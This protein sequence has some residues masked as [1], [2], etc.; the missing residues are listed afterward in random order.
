MWRRSTN[1]ASP[2]SASAERLEG[3]GGSTGCTI[4]PGNDPVA[5]L[6][7]SKTTAA[8][9]APRTSRKWPLRS[10]FSSAHGGSDGS[11]NADSAR[12]YQLHKKS[13]STNDHGDNTA[14]PELPLSS[15]HTIIE[16]GRATKENCQEQHAHTLVVGQS[17]RRS[18]L[19]GMTQVR[20]RHGVLAGSCHPHASD[21]SPL[22]RSVHMNMEDWSDDDDWGRPTA[23]LEQQ[24]LPA[25]PRAKVPVE[26]G[27]AHV[28]GSDDVFVSDV[29]LAYPRHGQTPQS[30]AQELTYTSPCVLPSAS[31]PPQ[32]V[33]AS[34]LVSTSVVMAVAG[35]P[36]APTQPCEFSQT[37]P[38]ADCSP[39][40][41]AFHS[42]IRGLRSAHATSGSGSGAEGA[43]VDRTKRR[44]KGVG[45]VALLSP[46]IP[47]HAALPP[48]PCAGVRTADQD[49]AAAVALAAG[50]AA[51]HRFAWEAERSVERQSWV[52]AVQALLMQIYHACEGDS[53]V[54]AEANGNV[55]LPCATVTEP[56]HVARQLLD[57]ARKNAASSADSP[58]RDGDAVRSYST[59]VRMLAA[60][61]QMGAARVDDGVGLGGNQRQQAGQHVLAMW[62][63][64]SVALPAMW[65]QAWASA[66]EKLA[67]AKQPPG[68]HSLT[69]T[70][71]CEPV[72]EARRT[73][74]AL[75]TFLKQT[76]SRSGPLFSVREV[77]AGVVAGLEAAL[78]SLIATT[79]A[80]AAFTAPTRSEMSPWAVEVVTAAAEATIHRDEMIK[81]CVVD[82]ASTAAAADGC[83]NADR[84]MHKTRVQLREGSWALWYVLRVVGLLMWWE[85]MLPHIFPCRPPSTHV[86]TEASTTGALS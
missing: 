28:T 4:Q 30:V 85:A 69:T 80:P 15:S 59:V 79:A 29:A 77:H 46:A 2:R 71:E 41:A 66:T 37:S 8:P 3:G 13:D 32:Q 67:G 81:Q 35:G 40:P 27:T 49:D 78:E 44:K 36:P 72:S 54:L 11:P 58:D 5:H 26:A 39:A 22:A 7:N 31:T 21:A 10:L 55:V 14:W 51:R 9:A 63:S 48:T 56:L 47:P 60:H 17:N 61:T 76:L 62:Q 33:S 82:V 42:G 20:Q 43:A 6:A 83:N 68:G 24:T 18:N 53:P 57:T 12:H 65:H 23:V 38:P 84:A 74:V 19:P 86:H 73:T 1:S 34:A 16:K 70:M 25:L 50:T 64:I 52:H 75:G 45:A